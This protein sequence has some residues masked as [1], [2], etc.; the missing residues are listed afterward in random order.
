MKPIKIRKKPIVVEAMKYNGDNF[1]EIREW[2][3]QPLKLDPARKIL[4]PTPEGPMKASRYDYIIKGVRGELYA[5]KPTFF[6]ETYEIL[7]D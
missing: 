5:I 4:L 3:G 1:E 7:E 2:S 6:Y